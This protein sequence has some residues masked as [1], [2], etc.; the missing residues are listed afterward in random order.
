[1]VTRQ[2]L[3]IR[4]CGHIYPGFLAGEV[5][6]SQK[7]SKWPVALSLASLSPHPH[8]FEAIQSP[9]RSF[10]F[11]YI[12][13]HPRWINKIHRMEGVDEAEAHFRV[14]KTNSQ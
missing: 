2:H 11:F 4:L 13:I 10:S 12:G 8:P 14:K 9:N 6:F 5:S 7:F 1:M 3:A